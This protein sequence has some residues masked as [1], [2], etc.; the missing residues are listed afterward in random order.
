MACS[1]PVLALQACFIEGG[2]VLSFYFHHSVMDGG[3]FSAFAA[4]LAENICDSKNPHLRSNSDIPTPEDPSVARL[5]IDQILQAPPEPA[6]PRSDSL[7]TPSDSRVLLPPR[8]S[9]CPTPDCV[10]RLF[11]FSRA[12]LVKLREE[13][14]RLDPKSE[15]IT[16]FQTLA[17]LI[18]T[19]VTRARRPRLIPETNTHCAVAVNLRP[20][21]DHPPLDR[22]FI[23]N[24]S[25][26]Y[27]SRLSVSHFLGEQV[28]TPITL[29]PA[30][31]AIR[32]KLAEIN[33]DYVPYLISRLSTVQS[34]D[35]LFNFNCLQDVFITSWASFDFGGLVKNW[36][37]PGTKTENQE[38][39]VVVRKPF[40]K[41]DR[42]VLIYPREMGEEAPYEVLIQLREDD[43]ERLLNEP[44][45]LVGRAVRVVA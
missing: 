12:S 42:S 31:L 36:G 3:G 29:T 45:G 9:P 8:L 21:V 41:Q 11:T 5:N 39:R 32:T 26:T 22:N 28:V 25:T 30:A 37:I 16:V 4:K 44:R 13:L 23:G 33:S 18:W 20:R 19:H 24:A 15:K 17:A 2:L 40:S 43:M 27:P 1:L 6:M 14:Q 35:D 38:E 7:I 10:P 34:V